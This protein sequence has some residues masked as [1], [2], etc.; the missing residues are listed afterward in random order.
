MDPVLVAATRGAIQR[1][2]VAWV[3]EVEPIRTTQPHKSARGRIVLAES[4][5]RR[6][7]RPT[8]GSL[9]VEQRAPP[10]APRRR[11]H[12]VAKGWKERRRRAGVGN[13]K[14]SAKRG[15]ERQDEGDHRGW[16][17]VANRAD[18]GPMR[19]EGAEEQ[20]DNLGKIEQME[21]REGERMMTALIERLSEKVEH[22]A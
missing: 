3:S 5:P 4:A 13:G 7:A 19:G 6:H 2:L 21:A 14:R 16:K 22:V 20:V 11:W 1:A 15:D 8:R 17:P 12:G 18:A 10:R 9:A